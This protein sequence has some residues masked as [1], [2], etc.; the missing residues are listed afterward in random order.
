LNIEVVA[1]DAGQSVFGRQS[2]NQ[3]FR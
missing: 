3:L 2:W 1:E